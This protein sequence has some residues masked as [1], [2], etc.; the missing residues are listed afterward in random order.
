MG[1]VVTD[2]VLEKRGIR[3]EH[4]FFHHLKFFLSFID[5]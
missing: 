1:D 3:W 4:E 2:P 5:G